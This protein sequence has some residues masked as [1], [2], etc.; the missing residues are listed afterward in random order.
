MKRDAAAQER[1]MLLPFMDKNSGAKAISAAAGR[2][3]RIKTALR[4]HND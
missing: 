3:V 4:K 1:A 2:A